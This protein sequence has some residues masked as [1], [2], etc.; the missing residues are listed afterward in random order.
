MQLHLLRS[1]WEAQGLRAAWVT[2]DRDDARSL[3]KDED[4]AFAFGPTTRNVLNLFRNL[5]LAW[6]VLRA[7]QPKVIVT[8]GAGVAV[9]FIW[10][11]RAL[12]IPSVYIESLTRIAQPSLSCR[13]SAPA[14]ARTYG[15]WREIVESTPRMRFAGR[16]VHGR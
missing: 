10:I 6:R 15:Q 14:A 4:V 9:P 2:L 13:L 11:G 3:L 8:T 1:A 16:V 12:G 7:R 5:T